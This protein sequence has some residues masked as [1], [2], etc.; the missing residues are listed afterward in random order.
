MEEAVDRCNERVRGQLRLVRRKSAVL[1]YCGVDV[2]LQRAGR[3]ARER[4]GA[5]QYALE[6][7]RRGTAEAHHELN[8]CTTV[9]KCFEPRNPAQHALQP[10]LRR[11]MPQRH[12]SKDALS[13]AEAER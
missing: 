10:R 12:Q 4:R 8:V 6:L 13:D 11:R 1:E 2:C 7:P 5:I 3:E 9:T